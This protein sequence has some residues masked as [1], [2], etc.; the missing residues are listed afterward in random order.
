MSRNLATDIADAKAALEVKAQEMTADS[1]LDPVAF[2]ESA[3]NGWSSEVM[4]C[5]LLELVAERRLSVDST[6]RLVL[7]S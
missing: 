5:A 4:A 6:R 7:V 1:R 2:T 3:R